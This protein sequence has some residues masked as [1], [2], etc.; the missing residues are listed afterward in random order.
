MSELHVSYTVTVSD[1]R[2]ASYFGLFLR[3]RRPFQILF[4][5][6]AGSFLYAVGGALGL[7]EV[8]ALVFFI[9]AAYLAWGLLM[10]AGT[11]KQVLRYLKS[12]E[13]M[14]GQTYEVSVSGEQIRFSM[15]GRGE[16]A[17]FP[18][19]KLTCVFEISQLFL[20]YTSATQ[21][22]LLPKRALAPEQQLWLRRLFRT[23][24]GANFGSRFD[25]GG[26]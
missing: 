19:G 17:V 14:I 5:V 23:A 18:L 6:L 20:V 9:G 25:K 1:F 8:N 12:P 16:T 21:V 22:Y 24:L 4:V 3:Y 10:L 11:E 2:K 26:K 15:P 7:G 13:S